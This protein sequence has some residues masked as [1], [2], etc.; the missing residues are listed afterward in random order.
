L[1]ALQLVTVPAAPLKVT[2]LVPWVEPKFEPL[3]VTDVP[4]APEV[5]E[6]LV[7]LG[8]G[9]TVNVTPLLFTPPAAVTIT[10]PVV[11]PTGTVVVIWVALQVLIVAAVPLNVTPPLP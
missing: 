11:A 6:M 4:V 1:V 7:M 10:L 8:G 2:V 9:V 3:T 5:G